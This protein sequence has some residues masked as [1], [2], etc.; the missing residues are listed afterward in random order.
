[1]S[2]TVRAW[3]RAGS[4]RSAICVAVM[5]IMAMVLVLIFWECVKW[6]RREWRGVVVFT[7]DCCGGGVDSQCLCLFVA[8]ASKRSL[9]P[10]P[11][12]TV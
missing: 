11:L 3:M 9:L 1:M 8:R 10:F 2:E 5:R 12:R 7:R 4:A 6:F